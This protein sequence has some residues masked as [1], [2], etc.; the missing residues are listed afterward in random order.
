MTGGGPDLQR[1]LDAVWELLLPAFSERPLRQEDSEERILQ[2]RLAQLALPRSA[3]QPF[4]PD[5]ADRW[6]RADFLP[7]SAPGASLPPL[8]AVSVFRNGYSWSI[9]LEEEAGT[10][11]AELS[12]Q[13]LPGRWQ[14][15]GSPVF[16]TGGWTEPATLMADLVFVETP[17][18]LLVTCSLATG[19]FETRW[20]TVPTFSEALRTPALLSSMGAPK[21]AP[22][23]LHP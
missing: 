14:S 9:K 13:W 2:E 1:V 23:R 17:H 8:R 12:P 3:A 11:T 4:P 21:G 15:D 5:H 18:H 10:L 22:G 7:A 6:E 20:S 19:T 16:C